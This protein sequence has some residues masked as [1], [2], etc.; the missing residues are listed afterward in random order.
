MSGLGIIAGAGDLPRLI[1]EDRKANGEPTLV[2]DFEGIEVDWA[3][4][5]DRFTASF[6][7]PETIFEALKKSGCVHVVMAGGMQ[8][9]ALDPTRFDPTFAQIAPRLIG[10]LQEGDDAALRVVLEMFE[11][12][13]FEVIAPH[14]AL[15]GLLLE[16]GYPTIAQPSDYDRND[17]TRAAEILETT[18]PLD[19]GQGV[20]VAG[21]LC[22]GVETLQGTQ[23]LLDFVRQSQ[24]ELRPERG[25]LMKAPKT[26]QETRMDFPAIGPDT[27]DQLAMA[28]LSGIVVPANGV[29]VIHRDEVINRA[30]KYGLFIWSRA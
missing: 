17:A 14:S 29:L 2:I 6:E 24:P 21:G 16:E 12:A 5:F 7:Q 26:G 3:S 11:T 1:A 19:I 23:A 4:E 27:M 9:P 15:N 28:H 10:A 22:L 13:G 25:I 20:V 18:G 8:R 30:D